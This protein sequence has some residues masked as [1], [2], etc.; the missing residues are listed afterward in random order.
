MAEKRKS[1]TSSPEAVCTLPPGLLEPV[2]DRLSKNSRWYIHH[3]LAS[4]C[5][6]LLSHDQDMYNPFCTMIPLIKVNTTTKS[7]QNLRQQ[8]FCHSRLGLEAGTRP[9]FKP[10]PG[11]AF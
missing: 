5:Q 2:F 7:N 3:F 8:P 11:S 1:V 9:L 6:D 4:V 10:S